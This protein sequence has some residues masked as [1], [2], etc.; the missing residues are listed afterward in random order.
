MSASGKVLRSAAVMGVATFLSRIL[1]LV[2]EQVFA[3]FFGAGH[4]VDAFNI[5]FRIPNLLRDLFA[6][7]S[8]SAALV[9]TFTRVREKVGGVASWALAH[10]VFRV[11]FFWVSM[12]SVLGMIFSD[13]LVGFYA[14]A[15]R[16]V[17]GKFELAVSLTRTLFPFFPLVALAAAY[18][19]V[20]N[21]LGVFFV[22]AFASAV[23]NGV[24]ISTGVLATWACARFQIEPIFGMA[25]GVV[26]GGAA[27]ALCQ[28]P[29]LSKKRQ[30]DLGSVPVSVPLG[31]WYRDPDL[32]AMLKLMVPGTVGLAATQVSIL[33]N[34]ILATAAGSGAVSWL[35]Y[36]FRLMQFPIGVFGVSLAQATLP[37]VSTQWA[38]ADYT[39]TG[40]TLLRSLAN[41]FAINLP[42]A[43]GLAALAEPLIALLFE[44]G[45]FGTQDTHQTAMALAAYSVGLVAYSGVKVLAPCF[46][47]FGQVRV[48]VV[49]S[50]VSVGGLLILNLLSVFWLG[51]WGLALGTSAGAFVNFGILLVWACRVIT[52]QGGVLSVGAVASRFWVHLGVAAVMGIVCGATWKEL[53]W[54]LGEG[55]FAQSAWLA[56]LVAEGIAVVGI[57]W[58]LFGVQESSEIFSALLRKFGKKTV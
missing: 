48:P 31:P 21:S 26:L 3:Y 55:V 58:A 10:R 22:P 25:V 2:R 5:A 53:G 43:A 40:G 7:G 54:A 23:F 8:M 27:Q 11:L 39:G 51:F 16:A 15:F 42:A 37:A 36:A 32:R 45:R 29:E 38:R 28:L 41:V 1:G 34:S 30:I 9:P 17:P 52:L 35:N 4:A 14:S 50:L 24:S 13:V 47:A 57:L 20:L 44:H 46:Y 18:M 49:A 12:L 19:A 33:V 56:V 6:E